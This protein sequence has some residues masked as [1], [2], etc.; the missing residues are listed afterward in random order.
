MTA[1]RNMEWKKVEREKGLR[2]RKGKRQ[3]KES[4][5]LHV[6]LFACPTLKKI[7][8]F[9]P[10]LGGIYLV[11]IAFFFSK[12]KAHLGSLMT[13]FLF[14][15]WFYPNDVSLLKTKR[16]KNKERGKTKFGT[17]NHKKQGISNMSPLTQKLSNRT[18]QKSVILD[19]L[20]LRLRERRLQ[21]EKYF[22]SLENT[23]LDSNCK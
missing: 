4:P 7:A 11:K 3:A 5:N 12:T 15:P 8:I 2:K 13:E 18:K 22:T 19:Y 1:R 17:G 6:V 23:E 20:G 10:Y 16:A 21:K 14:C 9:K